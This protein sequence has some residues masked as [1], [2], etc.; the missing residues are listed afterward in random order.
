LMPHIMPKE[1]FPELYAHYKK[2]K[3]GYVLSEAQI[4]FRMAIALQSGSNIDGTGRKQMNARLKAGTSTEEWR[5]YQV[6]IDALE[7]LF[8]SEHFFFQKNQQGVKA[9]FNAS[10][11][12]IGAI[13]GKS[14]FSSFVHEV[15]HFWSQSLSEDHDKRIGAH[16]G[17]AGTR[18][19][20]E[21]FARDFERYMRDGRSPNRSL[22]PTFAAIKTAMVSVYKSLKGTPIEKEVHPDVKAVFDEMLGGTPTTREK[23][24]RLDL[25]NYLPVQHV[26]NEEQ[27][28]L[29]N[30]WSRSMQRA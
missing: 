4:N 25:L 18:E 21:G 22:I 26:D 7:K 17:K 13:T 15:S 5:G 11:N 30:R 23:P 9:W 6:E 10:S 14:D 8:S 19:R 16:Y 12:T 24:K 3:N 2:D 29:E 20:E 1:L 28:D 27:N